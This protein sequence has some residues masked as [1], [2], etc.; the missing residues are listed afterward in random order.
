[1]A[2]NLTPMLALDQGLIRVED[3]VVQA[4]ARQGGEV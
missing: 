1:M 4:V 2:T 3:D